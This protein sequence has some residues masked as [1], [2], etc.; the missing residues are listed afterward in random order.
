MTNQK[1]ITLDAKSLVTVV[2]SMV[3]TFA[4][5]VTSSAQKEIEASKDE[6]SEEDIKDISMKTMTIYLFVEEFIKGMEQM[7]ESNE[8]GFMDAVLSG[9]AEHNEKQ[10]NN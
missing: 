9:L 10:T 7:R 5:A 1:T 6:L 2:N 8:E 4:H 3:A